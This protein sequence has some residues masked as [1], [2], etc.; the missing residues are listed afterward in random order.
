MFKGIKDLEFIQKSIDELGEAADSVSREI[1]AVERHTAAMKWDGADRRE[2][3]DAQRALL[4]ELRAVETTLR[5][6]AA[7]LDAFLRDQAKVSS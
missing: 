3:D 7:E 1:L 6:K 4:A 5:A 2:F